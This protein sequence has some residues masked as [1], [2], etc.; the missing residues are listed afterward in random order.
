M[1]EQTL[2][3]RLERVA[4]HMPTGARLADIGSDHAYLPVALLRRGVIATA[5]AGEVALTP[6]RAAER[7][8]GE[9]G[10]EQ[11]ISVR[12]ANGLAAI[13]PEDGITAISLC[14]MGGETIRDILDSGKA[15]LSGHERLILQPNGGEQ[16]LRQWLMENDYRILCEEVLRENRFYYEIIVA[17]RAGPV[18]YTAEELYFGPLQLQA[19][20]PTFLAKWQR[21]LRQK[22]KTLA[23]FA[24]ARQ[25]VPEEKRQDIARQVRWISALLA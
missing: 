12:Q 1:N 9:N 16:P 3:M 8:V 18:T 4:A 7:T 25:A 5:V 24:K 23:S 20:T 15:R 10:L 17:E 19:R 13:E 2:S 22:Q 11:W 14:G 6:L 21:L